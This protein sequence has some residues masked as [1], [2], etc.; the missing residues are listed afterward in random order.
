MIGLQGKRGTAAGDGQRS[1]TGLMGIC[2]LRIHVLSIR[3]I[4]YSLKKDG[5]SIRL[6]A[7]LNLNNRIFSL[8]FLLI[9]RL[10]LISF[11][12]IEEKLISTSGEIYSSYANK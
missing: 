7:V 1:Q 5:I 10:S 3:I 2:Y 8:R 6:Q 12:V 4:L 11:V 9:S